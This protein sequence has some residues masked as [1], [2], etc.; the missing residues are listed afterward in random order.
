MAQHFIWKKLWNSFSFSLPPSFT[1][2]HSH[3]RKTFRTQHLF[4]TQS[5]FRYLQY[6]SKLSIFMVYKLFTYAIM[7]FVCPWS[8]YLHYTQYTINHR[9]TCLIDRAIVVLLDIGFVAAAS[10]YQNIML[11][12]SEEKWL[13]IH[14]ILLDRCIY[15]FFFYQKNA[16][17]KS[18]RPNS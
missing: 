14:I 4:F 17:W 11:I 9:A 2:P 3:T 12:R 10:R 8:Q 6:G 13:F 16:Y 7:P 1:L 15:S 18:K 5:V